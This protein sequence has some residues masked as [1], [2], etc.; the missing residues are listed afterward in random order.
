MC[1]FVL[2]VCCYWEDLGT[3]SDDLEWRLCRVTNSIKYITFK[4]DVNVF[5]SSGMTDFVGLIV[6]H[7]VDFAIPQVTIILFVY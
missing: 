6:C 2:R 4:R 3:R 7:F 5:N 1:V